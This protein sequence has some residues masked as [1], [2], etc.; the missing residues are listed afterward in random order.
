L[1]VAKPDAKKR[2]AAE[3]EA[4]NKQLMQPRW[5]SKPKF[6]D[7]VENLADQ[8]PKKKAEATS[9]EAGGKKAAKRASRQAAKQ[10]AK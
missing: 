4:W 6:Q 10:P 8:Q 9:Q 5:K 3:F 2:L 7:Q 1:S